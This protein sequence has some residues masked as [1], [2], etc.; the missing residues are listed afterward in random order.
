MK[1]RINAHPQ[2]TVLSLE[3][4]FRDFE[5]IRESLIAEEYDLKMDHAENE[6]EFVSYL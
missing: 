4:S 6:A 1:T 3:D 5:I 2:L